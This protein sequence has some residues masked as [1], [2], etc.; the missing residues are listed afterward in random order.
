MRSCCPAFPAGWVVRAWAPGAAD[1]GPSL[2]QVQPRTPSYFMLQSS[3]PGRNAGLPRLAFPPL[4][5]RRPRASASMPPP[6][7]AG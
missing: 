5:M 7:V 6:G 1:S 3:G 2:P 4:P